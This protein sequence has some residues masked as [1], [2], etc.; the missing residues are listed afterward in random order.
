VNAWFRRSAKLIAI[1]SAAACGADQ[2]E[3]TTRQLRL[4]ARPLADERIAARRDAAARAEQRVGPP[5]PQLAAARDAALTRPEPFFGPNAFAADDQGRLWVVTSR[6]S[7][8]TTE[9]DLFAQDGRYV[10]T[11]ELKD[12]VVALSFRGDRLAVLVTR[13]REDIE[14][15]N[16]IDLYRI[17]NRPAS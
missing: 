17:T 16:G 15:F 1:V 14:G 3:A 8:S 10:Q 7:E 13:T 9:I 6:G 2:R 11:V 5:P 4:E 12:H